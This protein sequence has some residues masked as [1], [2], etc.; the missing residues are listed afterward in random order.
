MV[1]VNK[2]IFMTAEI[3]K[4]LIKEAEESTH[5]DLRLKLALC[6]LSIT[7]VCINELLNIKVSRLKT[8]TQE[9]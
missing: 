4:E 2:I 5:L 1:D 6:F 9:S 7:G 8:L 3:Y